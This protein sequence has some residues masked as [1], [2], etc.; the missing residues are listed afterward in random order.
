[1]QVT[2]RNT[3]DMNYVTGSGSW[4][5]EQA[6]RSKFGMEDCNTREVAQSLA[7]T[8]PYHEIERLVNKQKQDRKTERNDKQI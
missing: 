7:T 3:H 8:C 2:T 6:A 1:M 5:L 4:G